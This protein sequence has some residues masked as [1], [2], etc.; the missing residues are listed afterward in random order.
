MKDLGGHALASIPVASMAAG[1][2]SAAFFGY[3]AIKVVLR[4][5]NQGRL[6]VFSWYVWAL[7]IVTL[8]MYLS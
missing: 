1:L 6:S 5:V 3:I 2:L 4:L 8:V 7:G